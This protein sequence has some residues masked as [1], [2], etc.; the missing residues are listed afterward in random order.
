MT[1]FTLDVI[2]NDI[3]QIRK[4]LN[5]NYFAILGHSGHAYM[6]LE[7]GK[8]H[9]NYISRVIMLRVSPDLSPESHAKA[10]KIGKDLPNVKIESLPKEMQFIANYLRMTPRIWYD[11]AFNAADLW[12]NG[13]A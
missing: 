7:Y 12:K 1:S 6:A 2:I 10:E 5:L 11:Y 13:F 4:N 3:E 9:P 8:Q